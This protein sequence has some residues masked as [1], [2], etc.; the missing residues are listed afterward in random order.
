VNVNRC[1]GPGGG[2]DI[3]ILSNYDSTMLNNR[4]MLMFCK[5]TYIFYFCKVDLSYDLV[6]INHCKFLFYFCYE[7]ENTLIFI[8]F[9]AMKHKEGGILVQWNRSKYLNLNI[10]KWMIIVCWLVTSEVKYRPSSCTTNDTS[11]LGLAPEQRGWTRQRN[12]VHLFVYITGRISGLCFPP[13][14]GCQFRSHSIVPH[15]CSFQRAPRRL[16]FHAI[17]YRPSD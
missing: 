5:I 10:N 15:S 14:D 8:G 16:C 4:K 9:L 7:I 3:Y 6:T 12:T 17:Q 1:M 11:P 13:S 2:N